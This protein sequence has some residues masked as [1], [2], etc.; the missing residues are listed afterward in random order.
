MSEL[1]VCDQLGNT[2]VAKCQGLVKDAFGVIFQPIY[3]ETGQKNFI[4]LSKLPISELAME[5]WVNAPNPKS[6]MY[7]TGQIRN[8]ETE[9]DE[10][11][12][13]D[14]TN[15]SREIIRQG[16]RNINFQMWGVG[17]GVQAEFDKFK[18]DEIG[19]YIVSNQDELTG[20]VRK[21]DRTKAY[22]IPLTAFFTNAIWGTGEQLGG[23][24]VSF[25]MNIKFKDSELITVSGKGFELEPSAL[26]GLYTFY[27]TVVEATETAL[28]VEFPTTQ[29]TADCTFKATGLEAGDFT[30]LN[31]TDSSGIT[32][33]GVSENDERQFTLTWAGGDN[34][35]NGDVLNLSVQKNGGDYSHVSKVEIVVGGGS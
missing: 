28:V 12:F 19:F 4:D 27:L 30:L 9:R 20:L 7:P 23:I 29:G 8:F 17:A 32:I 1:C 5:G 26:R 10:P 13:Q 31:V 16:N 6:R 24:S 35:S 15:G 22:P 33:T 3:N 21:G 11:N 14:D 34:P 25:D 2:A 18:N